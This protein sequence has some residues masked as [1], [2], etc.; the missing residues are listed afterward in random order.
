MSRTWPERH[1]RPRRP[2]RQ[3]REMRRHRRTEP[4]AA[5]LDVAR[6]RDITTLA[7]EEPTHRLR[8][9]APDPML[10]VRAERREQAIDDYRASS[11][12]G[13]R[14]G[15]VVALLG[16]EHVGRADACRV[17]RPQVVVPRRQQ[18]RSP[19]GRV[20]VRSPPLPG[21]RHDGAGGTPPIIERTAPNRDQPPARRSVPPRAERPSAHAAA[22]RHPPAARTPRSRA[23]RTPQRS[24]QATA[25]ARHDD[26]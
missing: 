2:A 14:D 18:P 21:R 22:A 4:A 1:P 20:A 26:R 15:T 12:D 9:A 7:G 19:V 10:L 24:D 3:P 16:E 17:T 5:R 8:R 23:R 25:A 13:A 6:M 11:A